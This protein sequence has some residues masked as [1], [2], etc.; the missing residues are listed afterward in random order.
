MYIPGSHRKLITF[1]SRLGPLPSHPILSKAIPV[2][3]GGQLFSDNYSK[4]AYQRIGYKAV[5]PQN[6]IE[7]V[8]DVNVPFILRGSF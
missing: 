1:R 3:Q 8:L 2:A 5:I 6:P 4:N 7:H